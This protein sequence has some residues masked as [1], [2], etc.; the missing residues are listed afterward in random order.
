MSLNCDIVGLEVSQNLT[1]PFVSLDRPK[2]R[3]KE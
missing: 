2:P 3:M 1:E